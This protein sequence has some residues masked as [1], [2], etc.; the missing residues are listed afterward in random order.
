VGVVSLGDLSQAKARSAG[1]VLR[2][3]SQPSI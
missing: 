1:D 3:I 2:E